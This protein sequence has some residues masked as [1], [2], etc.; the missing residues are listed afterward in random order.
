LA[1][2]E[3]V[4]LDAIALGHDA[5]A[6][7]GKRLGG[8]DPAEKPIECRLWHEL[9]C[10]CRRREATEKTIP[11]PWCS[12]RAAWSCRPCAARD[13]ADRCSDLRTGPLRTR[14][15]GRRDDDLARAPLAP[16]GA[17]ADRNRQETRFAPRQVAFAGM[18][19]GAALFAVGG[20]FVKFLGLWNAEISRWAA[21]KSASNCSVPVLTLTD[22]VHG[23]ELEIRDH[24]I[25]FTAIEARFSAFG[26]RFSVQE[27][28]MSRMLAILVRLAERQ[29]LTP[30]TRD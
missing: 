17:D 21:K 5:A 16:S 25:R 30:T 27:E 12:G 13:I 11:L 18:T 8:V 4:R 9:A 7:R 14:D 1:A 20:V 26:Q 2:D 19:A 6:K 28:R 15:V 3:M 29:G 24:K 10:R 23:L 22:R